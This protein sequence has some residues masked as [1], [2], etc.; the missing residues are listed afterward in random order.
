[1]LTPEEKEEMIADARNPERRLDFKA[2][3]STSKCSLDDYI[4]FLDDYQAVFRPFKVLKAI[5]PT[6][7]NKL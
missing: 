6:R 3:Q 1:M 4:T 7:V 5:T 2:G